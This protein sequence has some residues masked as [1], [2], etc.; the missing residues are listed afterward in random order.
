MCTRNRLLSFIIAAVSLLLCA[1]VHRPWLGGELFPL[2]DGG[3]FAQMIDDVRANGQ[4]IPAFTTYNQLDIPFVYPPLPFL[5]GAKLADFFSTSAESVLA[6]LPPILSLGI[7][8]AMTF[9]AAQ[10]FSS[11]IAILISSL[12]FALSSPQWL[13]MGGGIARA[14]GLLFAILCCSIAHKLFSS[15]RRDYWPWL[16]LWAALAALSHPEAPYFLVFSLGTLC[17]FD[18]ERKKLNERLRLGALAAL[19]AAVA[20][21]PWLLPLVNAHGLEPWR[22][23]AQTGAVSN[24]YY[25]LWAL[26]Y[27]KFLGPAWLSILAV[28]GLLVALREKRLELGLWFLLVSIF[29]T[30][31]I[32]TMMMVPG[33]LLAGLATERLIVPLF[34]GVR[35]RT[36]VLGALLLVVL[37]VAA[38]KHALLENYSVHFRYFDGSRGGPLRLSQDWRETFARIKSSPLKSRALWAVPSWE[39]QTTWFSDWTNEW[40]PRLS[41]ARGLAT[42]QGWEW[43]DAQRWSRAALPY[44]WIVQRRPRCSD[45]LAIRKAKKREVGIL[46]PESESLRAIRYRRI[47]QRCGY[48]TITVRSRSNVPHG[49][50]Q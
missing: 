4:R 40:L 29:V 6:V 48:M 10:F 46:L 27:F 3:M 35:A 14:L 9:L 34:V 26:G 30:R 8:A 1:L 28:C 25:L 31:S 33:A 44:K 42:A 43:K 50:A 20:I 22:S 5:L 47:M 16:S 2:G 12:P 18:G 36:K 24:P 41:G 21:T 49:E 7:V 19:G 38:A 45:V 37:T 32:P 39:G 15:G 17:L 23:A 11:P 13:W